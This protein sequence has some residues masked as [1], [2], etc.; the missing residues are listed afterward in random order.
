MLKEHFLNVIFDLGEKTSIP[1]SLGGGGEEKKK[2]QCY[3]TFSF[4]SF[5]IQCG[6][7]TS[8]KYG[9]KTAAKSK[10]LHS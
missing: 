10:R 8:P 6:G 3:S 1:E 7:K 9:Y 2:N 5:K 4:R